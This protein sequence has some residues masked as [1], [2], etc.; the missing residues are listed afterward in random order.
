MSKISFSIF[1]LSTYAS[2]RLLKYS[3]NINKQYAKKKEDE[4][5]LLLRSNNLNNKYTK[6]KLY[7]HKF[8]RSLHF[9]DPGQI[10]AIIVI[11]R[12]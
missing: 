2:Y 7:K 12:P 10:E 4:N 6:K 5:I 9:K 3:N 11:F 1:A 8:K